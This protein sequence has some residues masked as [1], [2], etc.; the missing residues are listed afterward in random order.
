M[1]LA[2]AVGAPAASA[3]LDPAAT[4]AVGGQVTTPH[5]Y[6]VAELQTLPQQDVV[7]EVGGDAHTFRGVS[8]DAL[9]TAAD[10][11]LPGGH[12]PTL[13]VTAELTGTAG[14]TVTLARG[15]LL[16]D[17]GA[18]DAV[19]ALERDG[20]ELSNGPQLVVG[21]DA[22]P[23]RML[24]GIGQLDIAVQS[25]MATTPPSPGALTV[26]GPNST[27]VLDAATLAGLPAE[28]LAVSFLSG[29]PPVTQNR[30]EVGPML[31]TVLRA[32]GFVPDK[33]AWVAAVAPDNYVAVVTPSEMTVGGRLLQISL[34]EDS[35]PLT[36]P[37]LIVSGDVRGGRY[38]SNTYDLVV[39]CIRFEACDLGIAGPPGPTG[40][41]GSDGAPGPAGPSGPAGTEGA[42]GPV[43]PVGP[44]GPAGPQG[45]P[46][47]TGPVGPKGRDARVTCRVTNA[48]GKPTQ[49]RCTVTTTGGRGTKLRVR[50]VRGQR[51][52]ASGRR[53]TTRAAGAVA[54][55][56]DGA[57]ALR[58]GTYRLVLTEQRG[59]RKRTTTQSAVVR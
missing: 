28:T 31:D 37:R 30:T 18:K 51:T 14:R 26:R 22:Q 11:V 15:E 3:A 25:P 50:L 36:Q 40:P 54:V 44:V 49:V 41:A 59:A 5:T 39:G 13:R 53:T 58:R 8:V 12:N 55:T 1:A 56:L 24:G 34:N 9:I 29:N 19:L 43:G 17:F 45:V 33:V 21:G 2:S 6:T 20:V 7:A 23:T 27:R 10:P 47:P 35:A 42:P 38:V 57:R 16:A 48:R 46:G 4:V 52:V 32:A